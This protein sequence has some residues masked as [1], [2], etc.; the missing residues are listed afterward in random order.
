M[1]K[2]IKQNQYRVTFS[3]FL[4]G[5]E[6]ILVIMACYLT[7][8]LKSVRRRWGLTKKLVARDYPGDHVIQDIL[9]H[10]THGIEVNAPA[11][12]VWPWIAQIG[13]DR[14]GFY[15]YELLENITGLQIK[16]E[17]KILPKFQN[18]K[19]GDKVLFGPDMGYPIIICEPGKAMAIETAIDM[20]TNEQYD[21]SIF[22]PAKF[23]HLTWLWYVEP[24]NGLRSRFISR[25]RVSTN[26]S[27]KNKVLMG[28]LAEPII[29]AMDRKMCLGIKSRAEQ[30]YQ[31]S[32]SALKQISHFN[33]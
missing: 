30:L 18:P 6:G 5:I 28:F 7:I 12:F 14:G 4:Q 31:K 20:K 33:G 3:Q 25:N 9:S 10:F 16:N 22:K 15:S 23:L 29:F 32:N 8:F 2:K 27:L 19:V 26:D 1:K 24:L 21:P 11:E 17:D 13:K